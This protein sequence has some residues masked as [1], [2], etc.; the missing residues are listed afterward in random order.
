MIK[1][2]CEQDLS[3]AKP[4]LIKATKALDT[5]DP[6]DINNIKSMLKPPNTVK[7][8]MEAICVICNIPPV[9]VPNPKNPKEK[10]LDYWEA[11]RKFL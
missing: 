10:I 4:K 7:L 8:V 6:N 11:T 9:A 2:S 5:L 1:Q 3:I